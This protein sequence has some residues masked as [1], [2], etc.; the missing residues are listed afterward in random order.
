MPDIT[1]KCIQI[2]KQRVI[3]GVKAGSKRITLA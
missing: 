2:D 3:F 1:C